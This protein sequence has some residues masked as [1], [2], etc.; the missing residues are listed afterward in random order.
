MASI[1]AVQTVQ[2]CCYSPRIPGRTKIMWNSWNL[3][4]YVVWVVWLRYEMLGVIGGMVVPRY[5]M[6]D[7]GLVGYF[8]KLAVGWLGR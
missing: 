8:W 1:V 2:L 5:R 7:M 3:T 6:L 4:G